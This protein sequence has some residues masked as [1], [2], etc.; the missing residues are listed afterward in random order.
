MYKLDGVYDIVAFLIPK[1]KVEYKNIEFKDNFP[2]SN[3]KLI[4]L[5]VSGD[6]QLV[7]VYSN[8]E[9]V[10][11]NYPWCQSF[12]EGF[13]TRTP[14]QK[15]ADILDIPIEKWEYIHMKFCE[16]MKAKI[17]E[18]FPK[19]CDFT[20]FKD[21]SLGSKHKF[22]KMFKFKGGENNRNKFSL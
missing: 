8:D 1:E 15:I 21:Y 14:D 5:F 9:V 11:R 17:E 10:Y 3:P 19:C 22:D 20:D 4:G 18:A 13:D 6:T 7:E 12:D 2:V 16:E